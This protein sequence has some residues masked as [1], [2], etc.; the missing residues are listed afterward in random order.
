MLT[1]YC[2]RLASCVGSQGKSEKEIACRLQAVLSECCCAALNVYVYGVNLSLPT[3][4]VH[5]APRN[6]P[7]LSGSTFAHLKDDCRTSVRPSDRPLQLRQRRFTFTSHSASQLNV[8]KH[9]H[10]LTA[11]SDRH[12]GPKF[13]I[14]KWSTLTRPCTRLFLPRSWQHR[15]P[16][17]GTSLFPLHL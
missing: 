11:P 8:A 16:S 2:V 6:Q 1:C 3:S 13:T 9:L 12:Q 14:A 7:S 10:H 15:G 5:G 17:L 4:T